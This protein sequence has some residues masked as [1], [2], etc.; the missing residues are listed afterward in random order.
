MF[1]QSKI[2]IVAAIMSLLILVLG[3][4]F[5]VI[6]V[7]SYIEVTNENREILDQY[8]EN[9]SLPSS[10]SQLDE[11]IDSQSWIHTAPMAE[12][13]T[14]YTVVFTK[15]S[16]LLY[17]DTA[18][19]NTYN[20]DE[21]VNLARDVW[22]KGKSEGKYDNL[23]YRIA[24][25]GNYILIAFLDNTVV[26]NSA[27]TLLN[28]T[29]MFGAVAL[30]ILFFIAKYLANRIVQPLEESYQ[31]QRQ[32]ISDAGHELKTPVAVVNANIELLARQL[33]KN[34]WLDNIQYENDRMSSLIIQLLELARTENVTPTMEDMD[35]SHLVMG[36]MLPF[37]T[38]AYEKGLLL[39]SE[40]I[41]DIH[42]H[43][44]AT[45]LKQL[46]SILIDNAISHSENGKE[47]MLVLKRVK[48]HAVL[49][50]INDGDPIPEQERKQL[51]ERFYR[52]DDARSDHGQH[53]GLG[54]AIAKAIVESHKGTIQ[55]VC[56]QGKVSFITKFPIHKK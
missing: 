4:T 13:S 44:N 32:F 3:G 1:K 56:D 30:I 20:I 47:V 35:F 33:G 23:L 9:Y 28:Y 26:Q 14:F 11:R 27:G 52:T 10:L 50:V 39:N 22:N 31:K 18:D 25:K 45:Q 40:I 34:Q 53:Y 19:I 2:K 51:F 15:D 46:V 7:A 24:D 37:E 43:G 12:L 21:L 8:V 49:S 42:V 48:N 54:L 17:V 38:I 5:G 36:E 41:P 29:L 55:I 16:Q 6:Y